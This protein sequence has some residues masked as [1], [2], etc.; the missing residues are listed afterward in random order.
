MKK[1]LMV[2]LAVLLVLSLAACKD[3]G[4]SEKTGETQAGVTS[5]ESGVGESET[6]EANVVVTEERVKFLLAEFSEE[7]T[8][9]SGDINDY[10]F[11]IT[12]VEFNGKFASK[13]EAYTIGVQEVQGIFYIVEDVCYKYDAAQNKYYELTEKEAEE[14]KDSVEVFEKTEPTSA[15][16][17]ETKEETSVRTQEDVDEENKNVLVSR[18]EKYDLSVVGIPKPISEYEFQAT[19]KTAKAT[20]GETVYIIY[21]MENGAYTEFTFAVGAEKDYYYDKSTG[22]YKPLA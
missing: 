4:G 21:L 3:N 15:G 12:P 1:F 17:N 16:S 5:A 6:T 11:D 7:T 18:Y 2:L 10:F 13:A 8:G 22:E 9:L 14:V 20:D 19:G